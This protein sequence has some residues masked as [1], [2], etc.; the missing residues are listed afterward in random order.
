MSAL[1]ANARK[2]LESD[3]SA[4]RLETLHSQLKARINEVLERVKAITAKD[5]S[6]F[7][8]APGPERQRVISSGDV[9]A[10]RKLDDEERDL[11][12]ELEVLRA[13]QGQLRSRV[14]E[15]LAREHVANWPKACAELDELLAAQAKA[16]VAARKARQAVDAKLTELRAKR[17]HVTRQRALN[18]QQLD[19]P[20][21][22][23]LLR[24]YMAAQGYTYHRSPD[25]VGWFSPIGSPRELQNVADV[26]GVPVPRQQQA[27]A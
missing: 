13:L 8:N 14:D 12:A 5:T 7:A 4:D 6:L 15:T 1:I 27:A 22:P 20:A 25:R 26:L 17:H 21:A 9:A 10:V 2:A 18:G 23:E 16:Q 19:L 11:S 3:C 24:T